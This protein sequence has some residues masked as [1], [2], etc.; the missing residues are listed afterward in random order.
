MN[1]MIDIENNEIRDL[2]ISAGAL[3]LAFGISFSGGITALLQ[4]IA[5]AYAVIASLLAV[6]TGFILHELGHRF[7]ANRFNCRA[8]YKMWPS[9]L[10]LA[11]AF[12]LFGFVFAAP[13]AVVIYPRVSLWGNA[14]KLTRKAYGIISLSGP[15][16]NLLLALIFLV[17]NAIYPSDI[18]LLGKYVNTWLALFNLIPFMPFDGAKILAWDSRIWLAAAVIAVIMLLIL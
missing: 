7:M 10:L 1:E 5:L 13:G 8:E 4:P 16:M 12:S 17:I 9:G 14:H 11:L 2:V 6:S 3:A 15:V 18:F